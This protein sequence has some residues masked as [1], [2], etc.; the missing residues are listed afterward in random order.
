M[1]GVRLSPFLAANAVGSTTSG[2]ICARRNLTFYIVF[3]SCGLQLIGACL[4]MSLPGGPH[5]DP[6]GYVYQVIYGLGTGGILSSTGYMTGINS[7]YRDYGTHSLLFFFVFTSILKS[8]S[9]IFW[10]H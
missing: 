6:R 8:C 7:N 10:H 1:A 9:I 2:L 5:I 3:I 4:L